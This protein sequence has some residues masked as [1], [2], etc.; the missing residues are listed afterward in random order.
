MAVALRCL[1]LNMRLLD[2][3]VSV[4]TRQ[5]RGEE[6]GRDLCSTSM[7]NIIVMRMCFFVFF[8]N[9][10]STTHCHNNHACVQIDGSDFAFFAHR[11]HRTF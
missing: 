6:G 5:K 4:S 8:S 11:Q 3:I 2:N 7:R 1:F 10:C 9:E